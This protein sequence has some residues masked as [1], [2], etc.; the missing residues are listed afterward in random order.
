MQS[1]LNLARR[2]DHTNCNSFVM[3]LM[4]HGD[5]GVIYST[6]D[7][8]DIKDFVDLFRGDNCP[9]LNGKPKIFIFQVCF[10]FN[11][12]ISTCIYEWLC[13]LLCQQFF[14][15]F[16]LINMHNNASNEVFINKVSWE[17]RVI[18]NLKF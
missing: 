15:S 10:C 8:V 9:T 12:Y 5:E 11:K 6:D 3:A 14:F 17:P 16:L 2:T 4:S 7:C 18:V 1:I 13:N